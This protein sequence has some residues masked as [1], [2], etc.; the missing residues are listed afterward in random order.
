MDQQEGDPAETEAGFQDRVGTWLLECFG[1]E[2][3][4]DITERGDRFLEEVLEILQAHGYDP[5]RVAPLVAYV[6]GRAVGE[7]F[8]EMGGVMVTLAAF[9]HAAGI[10]MNQAGEAEL[11]R[12][13]TKIEQMREKQASKKGIATPLPTLPDGEPDPALL[14]SMATC[15]N[16]GF[17]LLDHQR[18]A[19]MLADMRK[20]WAEVQGKGYYA[21][22]R[23]DWYLHCLKQAP[24][25][26][27]PQPP[28]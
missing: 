3:A 14:V 13:W 24:K 9:G 25:N 21:P 28:V 26:E 7:P 19:R 23:R 2:V 27:Q 4:G 12:I 5:G 1:P 17:A 22:E 8:Q 11:A 16:H 15:L 6:F 18:Q 10:D 20:L